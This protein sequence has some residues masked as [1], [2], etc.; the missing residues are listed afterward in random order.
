[1]NIRQYY[2]QAAAISL[3]ASLAAFIPP[4]F[5]LFYS[6]V[7]TKIY[8][9]LLLIIPFLIY[10]FYC[11]QVF[12]LNKNRAS[13]IQ[14]EPFEKEGCTTNLLQETTLLLHFLP[15]PTLRLLFF[16]PSGVKVGEIRDHSMFFIRW[17]LPFFLDRFF[18]R[19]FILYNQEDKPTAHFHL[20]KDRIEVITQEGVLLTTV[21]KLQKGKCREYLLD[22]Q[23]IQIIK[24]GIPAN[25]SFVTPENRLFGRIQRGMMPL[26]WAQRF[27]N[28]NTPI[29]TYAE[30]NEEKDK[31]QL[32][33]MLINVYMYVDH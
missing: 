17:F 18:N 7:V 22:K 15:A 1:M 20:Y 5:I 4:I 12:L 2:E 10:S 9:L 14:L 21:F 27:V 16:K 13:S 8:Q 32:L 31:L 19:R 24:S 23:F 30:S 33:A 29:L 26:E 11:Y 25:Y 3:N 28:P 6:V